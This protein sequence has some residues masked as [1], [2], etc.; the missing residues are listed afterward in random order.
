MRAQILGALA[1]LVPNAIRD[2]R[3]HEIFPRYTLLLG[4]AGALCRL[5]W[6]GDTLPSVIGGLL[7]GLVLFS[8]AVASRGG[9]GAGDGL[10]VSALGTWTSLWEALLAVTFGLGLLGFSAIA[11]SLAGRRKKEYPFVPFLLAGQI[12]TWILV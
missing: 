7:P 4:G 6:F 1:V 3:R 10:A 12:L 11:L 8:F 5:L 9:I 2:L